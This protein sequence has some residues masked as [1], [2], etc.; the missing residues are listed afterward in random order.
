MARRALELYLRMALALAIQLYGVIAGVSGFELALLDGE[1]LFET[2]RGL[3]LNEEGA[4]E[5]AA[6]VA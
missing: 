2:L 3:V 4:A 1:R 6:A 5:P